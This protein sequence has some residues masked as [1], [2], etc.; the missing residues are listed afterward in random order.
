MQIKLKFIRLKRIYIF[1]LLVV[2]SI[3]FTTSLNANSFKI[4]DLEISEPFE[5]NFNKEKVID[6][7][8]KKAFTQLVLMIT[9]SGN[10]QKIKNTS[11]STIKGLIDSFTMSDENFINNEYHVKFDVNFNKKNTLKFFEKKNIILSLPKKKNLLIIPVIVDLQKDQILLFTN[12]IFYENWNLENK[13]YF[14]LN[15]ILPSEDIDDVNFLLKNSKS[16][17]DY[18]FEKT[19]KKYDLKDFI[20]TIIYKNNNQLRILSKI[21]LNNSFKVDNQKF[22]NIDLDKDINI[23]LDKL[24]TTYENYWKNINEINTSIKLPFTISIKA[25]DYDKIKMLEK[26]FGELDLIS[27][28]EILKFDNKNI[29]YKIIYNGSPD[30]FLNNINKIG[31]KIKSENQIWKVQ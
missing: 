19:I 13:K 31:I 7:A 10:V 20:I 21:Q 5:V 30:K 24:K 4:T 25:N 9:T 22:E 23:V 29:Y 18:S 14:L 1:F 27:K 2:L 16:I 28:F 12:N 15:Y 6:D 26:G 17:E 11:L 8:F 3:I